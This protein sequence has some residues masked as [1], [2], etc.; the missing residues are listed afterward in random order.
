MEALAPK[1]LASSFK[2]ATTSSPKK[3]ASPRIKAISSISSPN[4]LAISLTKRC[5]MGCPATGINGFG[6]V[7][8][9]G[10]KREPLPAIGTMIFIYILY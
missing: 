6:T 9:C 4:T 8:V 1:L 10:L 2:E 7:S 5:T 3:A